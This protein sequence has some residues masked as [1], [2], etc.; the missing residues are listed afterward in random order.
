VQ[1]A[2]SGRRKISRDL[3]TRRFDAAITHRIRSQPQLKRVERERRIH[4]D[5]L[6]WRLGYLTV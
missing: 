1:A 5:R 3:E 6:F 4:A 2:V